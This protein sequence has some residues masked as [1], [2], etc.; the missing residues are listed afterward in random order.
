MKT[1]RIAVAGVG[2]YD[3]SRARTYLTVTGKLRERYDL[4][5]VCDHSPQSLEA[6]R[7]KLGAKALYAD[8]EKMISEEGPDVV[9]ALV[10]TDGQ[11]VV[12]L[13]AARRKCHILTEIPYA[14]TLPIGD[15][16]AKTCS[17]NAVKWEIAENVWLW[18]HERLK[19]EIVKAG[20]LG[21]IVHARLWYTSGPYHGFNAIRMIL[22]QN[23]KRA[24]GYAQQVKTLPYTSYGGSS[25]RT[26]WWESAIV[27][28]DGGATCLFEKPPLKSARGSC[29]EVEGTQ[30]YLTGNG[31]DDE[32]VLY[33]D[34]QQVRYP[35]K[36]TYERI[37]G[38]RVLASVGVATE[39][40]MAWHNPFKELGISEFDDVAKAS[41][42]CSLHSA[43]TDGVGPEYGPSNARC[44]MEIWIA[45]RE[46]ARRG[47]S[48][49]NLPI[50][51][52]TELEGRIREE[53]VS[54]YGHDPVTQT[55]GLL[56]TP[57]NRLSV[58]WTLAG[59]L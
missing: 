58:M 38:E 5:A 56:T 30:G 9:F 28:L 46:S 17:E 45:I 49:V 19:R 35:F 6:V 18:P 44:D 14:I 37:G 53:Y 7:S 22:G 48:W 57:F 12:A 27:E 10:P 43:V 29:W 40:P 16:V 47:S 26:S 50:T 11:S 34:G 32:L 3:H 8:V 59:F 33:K 54:R 36:D 21:E 23:A 39:P 25:E 13:T 1:L 31:F 42:L 4:C 2:A 24:L 20:L 15:A 52:V 55:S 51:D 41:I